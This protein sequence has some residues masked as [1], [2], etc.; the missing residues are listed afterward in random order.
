[1]QRMKTIWKELSDLHS[2]RAEYRHVYYTNKENEEY[3]WKKVTSLF[4][5]QRNHSTVKWL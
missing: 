4:P 2:H 1:M 5:N 3:F